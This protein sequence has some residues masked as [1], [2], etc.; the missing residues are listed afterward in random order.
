[1]NE[2]DITALR[3]LMAAGKQASGE[4]KPDVPF[5][6]SD[7]ETVWLV[8]GD[9]VT[10]GIGRHDVST[11]LNALLAIHKSI[12]DVEMAVTYGNGR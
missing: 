11:M 12:C 6:D 9:G 4:W 7:G 10:L 3:L 1:M 2:Q 8:D 5:F